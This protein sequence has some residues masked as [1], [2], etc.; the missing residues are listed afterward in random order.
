MLIVDKGLFT[1]SGVLLNTAPH[2]GLLTC[3]NTVRLLSD[4]SLH[5]IFTSVQSLKR[6]LL[7]DR[8]LRLDRKKSA[9][10]TS[11]VLLIGSIFA[12]HSFSLLRRVLF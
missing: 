10:T 7:D 11:A 5:K 4:F 2:R 1:F 8:N 12:L 6:I 3:G 9:A